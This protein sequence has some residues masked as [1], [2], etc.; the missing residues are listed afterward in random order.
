MVFVQPQ[1]R[2]TMNNTYVKYRE[3]KRDIRDNAA[4][5]VQRIFRGHKA[6]MYIKRK[7]QLSS[8][9]RSDDDMHRRPGMVPQG[10]A[11][12]SSNDP[13]SQ[14]AFRRYRELRDNKRDLKKKLKKFD[15]EFLAQH[16]RNPKKSDK[17][18]IRPMY[19]KY[20]EIKNVLE[21]LR[22]RLQQGKDP[23]P[24]DLIEEILSP[25]GAGPQDNSS[26]GVRM[27]GDSDNE[28]DDLDHSMGR[29]KTSRAAAAAESKPASRPSPEPAP[30]TPTP[31]DATQNKASA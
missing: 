6:R 29:S 12:G 23:I 11:R 8:L 3:L 10:N 13:G 18:V 1:E 30:S 7:R 9:S 24:E 31:N 22:C 16:G 14:A 15:E 4:A 2:G 21:E 26:K 5:D 17:E 27:S 28:I 20:H 19:Q 25:A